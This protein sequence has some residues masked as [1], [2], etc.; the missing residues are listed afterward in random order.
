MFTTHPSH[1]AWLPS[2]QLKLSIVR[3]IPKELPPTSI[4]NDLRPISLTLQIS[5]IMERFAIKS[6]M[7]QV[8]DHF[9]PKQFA[10][11]NKSTTHALVYLLYQ[12]FAALDSGHNYITLFFADF[13]KGFDLV[14]H[15][16]IINELGNLNVHPVL[17][18]W[19][20]GFLTNR[21]QCVKVYC[22]QS[23]WREITSAPQATWKSAKEV[24]PKEHV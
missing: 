1:K 11:P 15:N 8:I 4:E 23:S 18:R 22:H 12:I 16:V 20:T 17:T 3:P 2:S 9:D 14:E 21:Q 5:K 13:R 7:P 19:I 6:L 24:Y 10:L